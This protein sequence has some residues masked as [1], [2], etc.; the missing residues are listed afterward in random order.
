MS[1]RTHQNAATRGS[2]SVRPLRR[3]RYADTRA[4]AIAQ[5]L[6]DCEMPATLTAAAKVVGR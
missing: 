3:P 5:A 2:D 4:A 1:S 6:A